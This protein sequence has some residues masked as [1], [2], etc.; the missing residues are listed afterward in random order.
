MTPRPAPCHRRFRAAPRV[1][2]FEKLL[3]PVVAAF[4]RRLW[5][6]FR[7][8]RAVGSLPEHR[9]ASRS[10]W[11]LDDWICERAR[12]SVT[13]SIRFASLRSLIPPASPFT[14]RSVTRT[15]RPFLS[16]EFCPSEAFSACALGPLTPL[17]VRDLQKLVAGWTALEDPEGSSPLFPPPPRDSRTARPPRQVNLPRGRSH[18]ADSSAA[19]DAHLCATRRPRASSPLKGLV[20]R[21]GPPRGGHPCSLD[22]SLF[23]RAAPNPEGT[24]ARRAAPLKE[25][26]AGG[27][28][29][30]L[31]ALRYAGSY[32]PRDVA[33]PRAARGHLDLARRR[34]PARPQA[35]SSDDSRRPKAPRAAD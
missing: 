13:A 20:R 26:S 8:R 7:L 21:A 33:P 6:R 16:W 35:R 14:R 15:P 10:S 4:P 18:D 22:L 31:E 2:R 11:T 32:V 28:S 3:V 24:G 29:R 1:L 9:G 12:F 27:K 5:T 34:G 19:S 25:T 17:Q 23:R 30:A